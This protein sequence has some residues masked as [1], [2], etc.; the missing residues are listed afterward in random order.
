[1]QVCPSSDQGLGSEHGCHCSG[2][3]KDLQRLHFLHQGAGVCVSYT[4]HSVDVDYPT[5]CCSMVTPWPSSPWTP[6]KWRRSTSLW[7]EL[8]GVL[9]PASSVSVCGACRQLGRQA[10]L[11]IDVIKI[12]TD[13]DIQVK[14][15]IHHGNHLSMTYFQYCAFMY[16]RL[17]V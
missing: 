7:G 15:T 1:M 9:E 13:K 14:C 3:W 4:R 2:A 11:V 6:L 10:Q 8:W 16:T 17:C 12:N 5:N